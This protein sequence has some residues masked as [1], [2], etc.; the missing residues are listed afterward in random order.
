MEGQNAYC[1]TKLIPTNY[2]VKLDAR[3]DQRKLG[4]K[5][6]VL[7]APPKKWKH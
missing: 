5:E 3:K 4:K 2:V 1:S 6:C 7:F